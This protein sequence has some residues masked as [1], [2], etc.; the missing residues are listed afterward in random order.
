M[1]ANF[2]NVTVTTA[3]DFYLTALPTVWTASSA[4]VTNSYAVGIG[5]T[6]GFSGTVRLAVAGLPASMTTEVNPASI[7]GSG[8]ADLTITTQ[9]GVT[10]SY[11]FTV[12]A[13][14]GTLTH[15]ANAV[16]NVTAG[17]GGLPQGR[18]NSGINGGGAASYA[19]SVFVV[20]N[21]AGTI[22]GTRM[23]C[24]SR[25]RRWWGTGAW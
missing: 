14:S 12:T 10:G 18:L 24:N 11:A 21:Q 8:N 13:T 15:T 5:A 3:A 25:I 19:N 9:P 2:D 16:L 4:G 22:S 20:Q 1:T 17:A 7:A 6:N 23:V